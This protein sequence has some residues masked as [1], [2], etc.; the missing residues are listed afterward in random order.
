MISSTSKKWPSTLTYFYFFLVSVF[1]NLLPTFLHDWRI[2]FLFKCSIK[3]ALLNFNTYRNF[4]FHGFV[5]FNSL[6]MYNYFLNL[7]SYL[8]LIALA[9]SFQLIDLLSHLSIYFNDPVRA[10][11]FIIS[12]HWPFKLYFI[13]F[14]LKY[15]D[16]EMPMYLL[17]IQYL[18][19]KSIIKSN[20]KNWKQQNQ[21]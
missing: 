18:G 14:R 17:R 2:W 1:Y 16:S 11:V 21:S 8:S 13:T 20:C 19:L 6:L 5:L 12:S 7:T 9:I 10:P 3:I 4:H 15:R